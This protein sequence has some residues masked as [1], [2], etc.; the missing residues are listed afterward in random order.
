MIRSKLPNVGTTIFTVMSALAAEHKAINLSQGFPDFMPD[1]KLIDLV[2]TKMLEGNNQYPP[3]RGST[4]L[5][6]AIAAKI[7]HCYGLSVDPLSE[8]TVTSGACEAIYTAITTVVHPGDEVIILEPAYD[9]YR[10]SIEL[11]QGVPVP[12]RLKA[13]DFNKDWS[14][15]RAL[16]TDKT[17]MIVINTPHNPIGKIFHR[18]DLEQLEALVAETGIYVLSDEVYEHITFDDRHESVLRYPNLWQHTF[19]CYS[20][21]KTYHATGWRI[22]YCVAPAHL[23][24]E[25]RKVHQYTVFTVFR[26][27]QLAIADYMQDPSTYETL[28]A[29]FAKKQKILEAGL[30]QSRLRPLQSE[31]SYFQLYDYSDI[32]DEKDTDFVKRMTTEYG[33]AAIP[34]S[35]FYSSPP[36]DE[37]LIRLCFGKKDETL[38]QAV[39]RLAK[40]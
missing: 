31:G 15:I 2:H 37:K 26:P 28:P 24:K 11:A 22:G 4:Q 29:F 40:I 33:V 18:Q 35:V 30:E 27:G 36:E 12:Y 10:P 25:F 39:E 16:V 32:S 38:L 23:T 19:A 34:L 8:I 5:L 7:E 20:F 17:R 21:G 1:E 9:L 3:M 13:P 6:E 14:A